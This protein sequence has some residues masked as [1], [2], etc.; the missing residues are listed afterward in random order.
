MKQINLYQ[1]TFRPAIIALPAR[2]MAF[3][4]AVFSLGMLAMY[5]LNDWQLRQLHQQI[6][7]IEQRADAVARQVQASAPT[8]R[9]ADPA[10]ELEAQSIEASIQTLHRAKEAIA[11][12]VVGSETGFAAQFRA[13]ALTTHSGAWLTG[14]AV[15]DSGRALDLQGRALSGAAAAGLIG[16]LRRES[17]FA[18]LSFSGLKITPPESAAATPEN[19]PTARVPPPFLTFSLVARETADSPP[20]GNSP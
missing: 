20:P 8:A 4:G 15:S 5:A 2:K 11:S 12:G 7:Q 18:G 16:N 10:V 3:S 13:L 1:A 9:Q 6:A 19:K 14:V 17:V